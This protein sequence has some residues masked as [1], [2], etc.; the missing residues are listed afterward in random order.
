MSELSHNRYVLRGGRPLHG[1][2]TI[3]GAKNA[4]VAILPAA[5][6]VGGKCRL[7]N[8]PHISDTNMLRSILLQMG[9]R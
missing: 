4:A 1:S 2:V 8:V 7:E 3:S 6:L 9:A 5:L